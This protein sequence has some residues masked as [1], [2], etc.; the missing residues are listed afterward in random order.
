MHR[1]WAII[2]RELR[3]FRRSPILIIMS[4]I[5]G[6]VIGRTGKYRVLPIIGTALMALAL[7]LLATLDVTSGRVI[8]SLYALNQGAQPFTVGTLLSLYALLPMLLAVTAG[9][10]IDRAG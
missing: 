7:G 8:I 6:R 10:L 9:R 3:R 4:L 2:E 5:S 1:T